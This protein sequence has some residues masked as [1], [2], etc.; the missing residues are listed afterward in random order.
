MKTEYRCAQCLQPIR[1]RFPWRKEHCSTLCE[2][3]A[4]VYY[5]ANPVV[6]EVRP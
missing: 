2:E 5:A 1:G 6:V 4:R 3:A